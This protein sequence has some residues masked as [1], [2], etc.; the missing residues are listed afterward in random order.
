[1]SVTFRLRNTFYLETLDPVD[2]P[3]KAMLANH[4]LPLAGQLLCTVFV[5]CI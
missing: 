5:I 3:I 4:F 1:M 2:F